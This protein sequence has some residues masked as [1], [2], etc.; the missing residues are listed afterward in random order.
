M[1]KIIENKYGGQLCFEIDGEKASFK[2]Y[3]GIAERVEIP[4]TVDGCSVTAIERKAF[5]SCKTV[6][7]IALPDTVIELG[8]W[9]FAHAEKLQKISMPCRDMTCGKGL[10]LGCGKLYEI[11]LNGLNDGDCLGQMLAIAVIYLHDYALFELPRVGGDAWISR[12][13]AKL[14]A[15]M[16]L[17]DLEGYEELWTCGEEDYE[18]KEYDIESY[19]VEKRKMKLRIAF[20]RLINPYKLSDEMSERLKAYIR[21]SAPAWEL[22]R[23]EHAQDLEFYKIFAEAG[24]ITQD[25]FDALFSSL[26][27]ANAEIK[28]FMLKYREE[29]IGER[30]AFSMFELGWG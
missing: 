6:R 11:M 5:L 7:E 23:E 13:D 25:N 19:P 21:D 28:A 3:R 12:W 30:D 26:A 16:E 9:A 22:I 1:E 2:R 20:F 8:D 15:L 10:F 17:D 14:T 27:D 18:G 4:Q 29:S 24:G